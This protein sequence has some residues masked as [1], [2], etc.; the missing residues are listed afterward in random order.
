MDG[1]VRH[2]E[3]EARALRPENAEQLREEL[4][5]AFALRLAAEDI[6]DALILTQEETEGA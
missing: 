2:V 1:E 4:A 5:H 3:E 6:M